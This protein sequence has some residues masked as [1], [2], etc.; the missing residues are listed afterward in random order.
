MRKSF[1]FMALHQPL[2]THA[3]AATNRY[4]STNLFLFF[5]NTLPIMS[6]P[7]LEQASIDPWLPLQPS[8]FTLALNESV[9]WMVCP[10]QR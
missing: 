8:R 3:V 4:V 5:F 10:M 6:V 2:F 9:E 1:M 7:Q